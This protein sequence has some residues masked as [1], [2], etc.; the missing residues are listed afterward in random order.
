MLGLLDALFFKKI[1]YWC[2]V[3]LTVLYQFQVNSEVIY[4]HTH[5]FPLYGL[6][7]Y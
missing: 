3:E 4:I 5:F 7:E 6:L 1:F 2:I